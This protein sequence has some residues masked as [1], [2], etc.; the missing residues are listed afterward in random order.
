MGTAYYVFTHF[1]TEEALFGASPGRVSAVVTPS[2]LA[3][4]SA[5]KHR[6]AKADVA[7]TWPPTMVDSRARQMRRRRCLTEQ[8]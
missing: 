5:N 1:R 3:D 6:N 7:A 2:L 8:A 4:K